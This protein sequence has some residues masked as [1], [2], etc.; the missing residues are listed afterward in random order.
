MVRWFYFDS[1]TCLKDPQETYRFFLVAAD[2]IIDESYRL[3]DWSGNG[4][5]P[6][7]LITSKDDNPGWSDSEDWKR[8][9]VSL[10]PI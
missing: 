3:S 6:S 1:D 7:L 2:Q 4:F 8:A 10:R 9:I 5:D